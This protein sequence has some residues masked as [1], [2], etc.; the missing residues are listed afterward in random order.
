MRRARFLNTD[1]RP[2]RYERNGDMLENGR[3]SVKN[4]TILVA[5]GANLPSGGGDS[6]RTCKIARDK[7]E[8]SGVEVVAQARW[9][10]SPAFPSGAGPDFTN[11]ALKV[12]TSLAPEAL[13]ATLHKVEAELG[14]ERLIRWGPR[15]CDLDL[16]GYGQ[17]VLP[18]EP[19]VREWM[20]MGASAGDCA[21]PDTLILP[22]PRA[23]ER[24]FVLGPLMDIAPEWRH[25]V[26]GETVSQMW[27]GLSPEA[28]AEIE[29]I[30]DE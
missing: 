20:A 19:I 28:R 8:S 30:E 29:I 12:S 6:L 17:M 13:L 24:A 1:N 14:R 25:P 5:V 10:K 7:I 16:I 4:V 27:A 18:T 26:S 15:V 22:H 11:G 2:R 3:N 9:R 23:H 21:P